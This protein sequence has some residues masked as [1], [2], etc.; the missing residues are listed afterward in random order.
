MMKSCEQTKGLSVLQHGFSDKNYLFD[1]LNHLRHNTPLKY[2]WFLPDWLYENK[3]L[4]LSTLVDD[5]TLKLYT[6]LHDIGK[7]FCLTIDE[8][9]KRHFPNHAEVSYNIFTEYFNN[10]IAADLIRRDMDIHLLKSDGIEEFC[11]NPNHITSLI[12]GLAE[13]HSNAFMFGSLKSDSYKIKYKRIQ[14]N[15][16]KII[17]NLKNKKT[18]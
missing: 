5:K 12:V 2:E 17:N 9:G 1:L 4:I 13:L 16:E 11:R 14:K 7:P 18:I 6:I 8:D 15:G 10:E 3:D